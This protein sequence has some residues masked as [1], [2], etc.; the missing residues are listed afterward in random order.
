[1]IS[2]KEAT[3]HVL[4]HLHQPRI[5]TVQ[6]EHAIGKILAEPVLADRDFP[7]FDRVTMDGIAIAFDAWAKGC[8]TFDIEGTQAAGDHQST[9]KN[10][11]NAIEVMTGTSLP[12]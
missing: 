11:R 9:L 2:V 5:T 12:A 6:I 7:P 4:R 3:G 8:R 10:S 1:M